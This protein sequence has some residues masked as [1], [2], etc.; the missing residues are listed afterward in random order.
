MDGLY[1]FQ[2]YSFYESINKVLI[3]WAQR[4]IL[5]EHTPLPPTII[6]QIFTG[7]LNQLVAKQP[8]FNANVIYD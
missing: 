8:N 5:V 2:K 6:E 3:L 1:K 7:L 4:T